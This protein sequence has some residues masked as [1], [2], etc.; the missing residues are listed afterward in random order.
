MIVY[1]LEQIILNTVPLQVQ[2]HI[3]LLTDLYKKTGCNIA[4][5]ISNNVEL[6]HEVMDNKNTKQKRDIL[7]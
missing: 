4:G 7:K 2:R 6:P 1:G 3:T 5:F